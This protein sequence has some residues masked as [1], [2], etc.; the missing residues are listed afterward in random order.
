MSANGNYDAHG[1]PVNML[2]IHDNYKGDSKSRPMSQALQEL[3]HN[4]DGLMEALTKLEDG[5]VGVLT[6][7]PPVQGNDGEPGVIENPRRSAVVEVVQMA[8]LKVAQQHERVASLNARL[9]V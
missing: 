5:L 8:S 9:E 6:A 4:L 3:N 7:P 2:T 1:N